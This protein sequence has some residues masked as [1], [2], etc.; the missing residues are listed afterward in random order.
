MAMI[1]AI[2]GN[3]HGHKW[4][5]LM[6]IIMAMLAMIMAILA[7]IMAIN[8]NNKAILMASNGN[9]KGHAGNTNGNAWPTNTGNN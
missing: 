3:N 4:Q 8:G 2:N 7:M 5:I 6:A 9:A 1:R